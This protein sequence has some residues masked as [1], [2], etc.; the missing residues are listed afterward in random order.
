MVVTTGSR[1]LMLSETDW[2][3][4]HGGRSKTLVSNGRS[5]L[6]LAA[7]TILADTETAIPSSVDSRR[8]Y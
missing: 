2:E 7:M 8:V 6:H 5:I 3:K 1:Y 4:T